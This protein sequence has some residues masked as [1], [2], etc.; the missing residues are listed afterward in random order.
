MRKYV[1]VQP[2]VRSPSLVSMPFE[3]LVWQ[4]P[5]PFGRT[6]YTSEFVV[7]DF[8]HS[9]PVAVAGLAGRISSGLGESKALRK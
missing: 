3:F 9:S 5:S 8:C 1:R 4:D 2:H 7:P 6:M